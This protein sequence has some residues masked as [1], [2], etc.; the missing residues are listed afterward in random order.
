VKG[1]KLFSPYIVQHDARTLL[2]LEIL[3][4]IGGVRPYQITLISLFIHQFRTTNGTYNLFSQQ[5]LI[6][7]NSEQNIKNFRNDD[8]IDHYIH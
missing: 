4:P 1:L 2:V 7:R 3:Y 6:W 8:S 5:A